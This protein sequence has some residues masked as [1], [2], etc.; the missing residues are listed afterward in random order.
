[1]LPYDSLDQVTSGVLV[2]AIAAGRPVIATEFPHARE[3]LQTGA[4]M[5][6]P[7][8][9][10]LALATALR[11]VLTQPGLLGS[12]TAEARRLAPMLS[13]AAVAE[14]YADL[15]NRVLYQRDA[16]AS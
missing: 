9:D 5:V 16:V 13:W 4:G 15:C 11:L 1:M 2:D 12:M 7:H 10:P 6:V 8:R 3:M 14:R